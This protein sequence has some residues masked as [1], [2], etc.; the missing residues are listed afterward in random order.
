[1]AIV[2]RVVDV[3][4]DVIDPVEITISTARSPEEAARQAL[5]VEVVRSGSRKDIV[6]RVYWQAAGQPMNMV[7]LYRR[8]AS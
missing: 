6:A 4:T 5:D 8:A 1:M 3:R 2:Y 7:R